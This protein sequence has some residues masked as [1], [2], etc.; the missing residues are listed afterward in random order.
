MFELEYP[1]Y[2][3]SSKGPLEGSSKVKGYSTA[4]WVLEEMQD[5]RRRWQGGALGKEKPSVHMGSCSE[6]LSSFHSLCPPK[7]PQWIRTSQG[8]AMLT[9]SSG[10]GEKLMLWSQRTN[11]IFFSQLRFALG[12]RWVGRIDPKQNFCPWDLYTQKMLIT[13][14]LAWCFLSTAY[15][16]ELL[17]C[18]R[19]PLGSWLLYLPILP[20]CPVCKGKTLVWLLRCLV[21]M[22]A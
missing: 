11:F 1:Q 14:W 5:G 21:H 3:E 13:E 12:L 22:M 9:F 10:A 8:S 6:T 16:W 2:S 19:D 18:A 17:W 20:S 4:E 7:S 15:A